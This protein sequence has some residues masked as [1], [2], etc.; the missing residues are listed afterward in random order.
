MPYPPYWTNGVPQA[1]RRNGMTS[2]AGWHAPVCRHQAFT[3]HAW[4][5][6]TAPTPSAD[7]MGGCQWV[8]AQQHR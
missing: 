8:A 6:L 2:S 5:D 7:R 1:G 3:G 4:Q